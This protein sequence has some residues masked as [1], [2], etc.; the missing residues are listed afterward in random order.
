[1]V[2]DRGA[3]RTVSLTQEDFDDALNVQPFVLT[4]EELPEYKIKYKGEE[5]VD[6]LFTYVFDVKPKKIRR[7][8]RYFRGRIW[9]D[10]LDLQIV[11]VFQFDR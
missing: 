9:V 10:N 4:T 2:E 11:K 8:K 1:M 7:G 6:E 5:Q 3:L